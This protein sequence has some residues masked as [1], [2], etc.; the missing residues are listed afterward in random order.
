VIFYKEDNMYHPDH[1]T[2]A[3]DYIYIA[4]L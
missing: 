1:R 3:F 4:N 2:F